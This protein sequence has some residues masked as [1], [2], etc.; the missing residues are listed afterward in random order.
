VPLEVGQYHRFDTQI[1][2]NNRGEGR[3]VGAIRFLGT[4]AMQS[5]RQASFTVFV[6]VMERELPFE[7]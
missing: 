2:L 3:Y 6:L 4:I 7:G 5:L 1:T